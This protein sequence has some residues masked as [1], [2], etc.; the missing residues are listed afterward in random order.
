MHPNDK[1]KTAIVAPGGLHEFDVM[2]FGLLACQ[3]HT[4]DLWKVPF[5][6]FNGKVFVL[7]R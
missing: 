2:P 4:N 3:K 7:P 5:V 6:H 1:D